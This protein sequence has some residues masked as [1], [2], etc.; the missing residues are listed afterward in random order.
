MQSH[1]NSIN[2]LISSLNFPAITH[3]ALRILS[4]NYST[5]KFKFVSLYFYAPWHRRSFTFTRYFL[6]LFP[7]DLPVNTYRWCLIALL[8]SLSSTAQRC[9]LFTSREIFF[10]TNKRG[11]FQNKLK[12]S[13]VYT[14]YTHNFFLCSSQRILEIFS[15]LQQQQQHDLK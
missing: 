13:I 7:S 6:F 15:L 5:I 9:F 4:L 12:P 14:I 10:F 1:L 8:A 2:R 3:D 11:F